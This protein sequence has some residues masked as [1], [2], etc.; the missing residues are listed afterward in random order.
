MKVVT[1]ELGKMILEEAEALLLGSYREQT[2]SNDGVWL[3]K[4][5]QEFDILQPKGN[6]KYV[7][8]RKNQIPYCAVTASVILDRAFERY[9]ITN[10][11]RT[12]SAKD[13]LN[14]AKQ[15]KVQINKVAKPGAVFLT[16]TSGEG[17]TS[18]YHAGIVWYVD[19]KRKVIGTIEG[20][21]PSGYHINNGCLV[22]LPK[23]WDGIVHKERPIS[24]VAN[25]I[26]V[27]DSLPS[28]ISAEH[29]VGKPSVGFTGLRDDTMCLLTADVDYGVEGESS[30]K[31]SIDYTWYIVGALVGLIGLS[32]V[33]KK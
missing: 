10:Y 19:E 29:Q 2:N 31:N 6:K 14:V 30:D 4:M 22:K 28:T 26:H 32:Y 15:H 21:T 33:I 8:R 7:N 9:G 1:T 25:F 27:Q 3:E 24:N 20:N 18:G 23:G 12:A 13:F 17:S 16:K 11:V 5:I